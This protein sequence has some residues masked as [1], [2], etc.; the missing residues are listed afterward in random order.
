VRTW[1]ALVAVLV[2]FGCGAPVRKVS[3]S[4]LRNATARGAADEMRAL[5]Y[6]IKSRMRCRTLSPDSP[7]VVRVRCAGR[8]I[9]EEP[10]RVEAVAY[11]A[12]AAHPRQQFVITVAGREVIRAP[13]LGQSCRDLR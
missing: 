3:E 10:V 7:S 2:V 12:N 11:D 5:G 9:R 6:P 8:T 1:Q 13:C 4:S